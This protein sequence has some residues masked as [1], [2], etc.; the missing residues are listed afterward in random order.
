MKGGTILGWDPSGQREPCYLFARAAAMIF[1][2]LQAPV[3]TMLKCE[4]SSTT[5]TPI[6]LVNLHHGDEAASKRV[7]QATR[8][9]LQCEGM[10]CSCASS[11]EVQAKV[12]F[13]VGASRVRAGSD[14]G[15]PLSESRPLCIGRS[16]K[17]RRNT[18]L[19]L[20][21]VP[22][23]GSSATRGRALVKSRADWLRSRWTNAREPAKAHSRHQGP[24]GEAAE[25]PRQTPG[26]LPEGRILLPSI[27][28]DCRE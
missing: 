7:G 20:G 24:L 10:G 4:T 6:T 22:A 12:L 11:H 25:E 28:C 17:K 3:V 21:T 13:F 16:D 15:E 19:P 8:L 1:A 2:I 26:L 23:S 18:R 27:R 14:L 9:L 5:C